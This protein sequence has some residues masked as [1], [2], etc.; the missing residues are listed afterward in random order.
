MSYLSVF[1]AHGTTVLLA[2]WGPCDR[3]CSWFLGEKTFVSA[4]G[5]FMARASFYMVLFFSHEG[6]QFSNNVHLPASTM[7]PPGHQQ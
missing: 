1:G 4:D 6:Q 7:G 5:V 3:I 2:P